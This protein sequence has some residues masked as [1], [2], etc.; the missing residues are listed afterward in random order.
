MARRQTSKRGGSL[1][2][3]RNLPKC[4]NY[5]LMN[6]RTVNKKIKLNRHISEH[7]NDLDAKKT[8]KLLIK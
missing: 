8:L 1:K 7:K 3:M 6:I 4:N 2:A 5:K